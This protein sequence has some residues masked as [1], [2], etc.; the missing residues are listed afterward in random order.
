[1]VVIG[2]S[3][4]ASQNTCIK[5][6]HTSYHYWPITVSAIPTKRHTQILSS[7]EKEKSNFRIKPSIVPRLEKATRI[8]SFWS[9]ELHYDPPWALRPALISNKFELRVCFH[10]T[11]RDCPV[12]PQFRKSIPLT[13]PTKKQNSGVVLR[14]IQSLHQIVLDSNLP[15]IATMSFGFG[16]GDFVAVSTL[17]L[18][19]Y[20]SFKGAPS[21]FREISRQLESFYIVLVDLNEQSREPTSLLNRNGASRR[22]EM[23]VLRD[24]LMAT[25]EELEDLYKRYKRM[26]RISWARLDFGQRDLSTLT[27]KLTVHL[28]ALNAFIGNLTI[29]ALGRME[30]MLARIHQLLDERVKD[31]LI[32]AQT[33]LGAKD[34]VAGNWDRMAMELRT[35]GIP[36]AYLEKNQEQ[37][38][39]VLAPSIRN[40]PASRSMPRDSTSPQSENLGWG[41]ISKLGAD[42]VE[43]QTDDFGWGTF[44]KSRKTNKKKASPTFAWDDFGDGPR[45]STS[46]RNTK[47][48]P[49]Q[50]SLRDEVYDSQ[51]DENYV[52]KSSKPRFNKVV[53]ATSWHGDLTS[54][55]RST[56]NLLLNYGFNIGRSSATGSRHG[57]NSSSGI[58]LAPSLEQ[59]AWE[60]A[61]ENNNMDAA[62]LIIKRFGSC[63]LPLLQAAYQDKWEFVAVCLKATIQPFKVDF[64]VCHVAAKSNRC[65][66]LQE[67]SRLG[68]SLD[69]QHPL[70]LKKRYECGRTTS[71]V[72]ELGGGWAPLHFSA[73][74]GAYDAAKLLL[75][76]LADPNQVTMKKSNLLHLAAYGPLSDADAAKLTQLFLDAGLDPTAANDLYRTPLYYFVYKGCQSTTGVL[77]KGGAVAESPW[78]NVK[79]GNWS[80]L[81]IA[82]KRDYLHM[83]KFLL[84]GGLDINRISDFPAIAGSKES[85]V[86]PIVWA[87]QAKSWEVARYLRE[88]GASLKGL[89]QYQLKRIDAVFST[90][91]T[92]LSA[93]TFLTPSLA[94]GVFA[95][96]RNRSTI[97]VPITVYLEVQNGNLGEAPK[98]SGYSSTSPLPT[99]GTIPCDEGYALTYTWGSASEGIAVTYTTPTS[100]AFTHNAPILGCTE[101]GHG[102]VCQFGFTDLFPSKKERALQ[103]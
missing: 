64:G 54:E 63:N 73:W 36:A 46:G 90:T 17:A 83:I 65:D 89:S 99:S 35:D 19:L 98:C 7:T 20:R 28:A 13:V 67:L 27:G 31:N 102:T 33:V 94:D 14:V 6:R 23:F 96:T 12:Q 2:H 39:K 3:Q 49:F 60:W 87:C 44:T 45:H 50:T 52:S 38:R 80:T 25:M 78:K 32:M 97:A 42:I 84:D 51:I 82:A 57:L 18:S 30:P 11:L 58:F 88:R 61:V 16:V 29:S 43:P 92:A 79:F 81:H 85:P 62:R 41:S 59:R 70:P 56:Q 40:N 77:L 53:E 9:L 5:P 34:D 101:E 37:I 71:V 86:T 22:Q 95:I 15:A 103:A 91:A 76:H 66:I 4:N 26:G 21:E 69:D 8:L 24:N 55:E 1:M 72:A 48:K 74:F 93:L 68:N 10:S 47:K 75:E 100:A